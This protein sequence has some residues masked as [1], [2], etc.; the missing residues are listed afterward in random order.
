MCNYFF[1]LCTV[2]YFLHALGTPCYCIYLFYSVES[3]RHCRFSVFNNM[4]WT[5][6]WLGKMQW[7]P[8]VNTIL[9]VLLLSVL[10]CCFSAVVFIFFL[11]LCY[12]VGFLS[13]KDME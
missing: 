5:D 10:I 8:C 13:N 2:M 11:G 7:I 1:V 9:P 4:G 12:P 3:N 6:E